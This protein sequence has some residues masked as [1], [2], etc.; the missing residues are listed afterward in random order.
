MFVAE[1][2][3]HL[4]S[5]ELLAEK[6]EIHNRK[7]KNTSICQWSVV[8]LVMPLMRTVHQLRLGVL[9]KLN[10]VDARKHIRISFFIFHFRNRCGLS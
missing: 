6:H 8:L 1:N 5:A 10:A 7:I 4:S 9:Y 2:A 3:L